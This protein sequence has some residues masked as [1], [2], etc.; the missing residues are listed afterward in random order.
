MTRDERGQTA[1]D[2]IAEMA[3]EFSDL[4]RL[5]ADG[6]PIPDMLDRLVKVAAQAV[7]GTEHCAITL[8]QGRASPRTIAASDELP[9]KVD[10]LQYTLQEGP[11]LQALV[12]SD[13]TLANDLATDRQWPTFA[14]RAVAETGVRAMLSFRLY[15]T[16][17]AQAALNFYSSRPQAFP[18]PSIA[19]GSIF[20][21][22]ASLAL[23]ASLHEEKA[24]NLTRAV[25]SN[26]EIGT[27]I[28]ILMA[29]KKVTQQD[30]FDQLRV[31]SQALHRKLRDIA[32]EVKITGELP[33]LPKPGAD[34]EPSDSE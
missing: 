2:V 16:G 24:L 12:V 1:A 14:E 22:Y 25:E 6:Q 4:A 9:M 26:R 15:L 8:V 21:A 11:C 27:A 19:T 10:A 5:L 7:T 20:A 3:A 18:L 23:L 31:A 17:A 29:T 30:A 33:D 28:G 34:Q 32:A 13:V